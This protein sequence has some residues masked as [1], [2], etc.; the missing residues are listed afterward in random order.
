[1]LTFRQLIEV[2]KRCSRCDANTQHTH[3][4]F[5][6]EGNNVDR[7]KCEMCKQ[8]RDAKRRNTKKKAER[9]ARWDRLMKDDDE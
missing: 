2:W 3:V 4:S 5:D 1:M 8:E 9:K 7:Y 6:N